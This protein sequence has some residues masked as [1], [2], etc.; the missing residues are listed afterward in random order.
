MDIQIRL[1]Q[2]EDYREAEQ[3]MREA[4]WNC[5]SPGCTEHYLLHVMRDSPNFLPELDFVA[6]ADGKIIGSVVLMKS[7]IISDDGKRHDVLSMGPIAVLPAFQRKGAGRMLIEHARA[8]AKDAGHRAILLCG[9]PRY[10]TRVGFT[11]AERFGI[12]TSENK[13]SAALHACPLYM[14][15]LKNA[16]GRYFEDEIYNVDEAAART[17][18][19]LFPPKE[20]LAGTP[21]QQRFKEILAMQKDYPPQPKD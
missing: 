4:F 16:A 15:A 14:D 8:A 17:F 10:Y 1:E 12:R 7:H 2:P 19:A 9:E 11:A 20:R 18:D 6:V 21:T 5:Y 3:V 13:Y